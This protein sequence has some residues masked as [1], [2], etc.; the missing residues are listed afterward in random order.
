MCSSDLFIGDS[1]FFGCSGLTS[2]EIPSSVTDIRPNV[3]FKCTGLTSVTIPDGVTT[4]GGSAFFGCSGLT[5]VTIPAS[6]TFIGNLAFSGCSGL[7]SVT[8]PASVTFIGNLAFSGCGGKYQ[9]LGKPPRGISNSSFGWNKKIVY[10]SVYESEWKHALLLSRQYAGIQNGTRSTV[11]IR[12]KDPK[13]MEV[14]YRLQSE[15]PQVKVR[16]VAFKDGIRSFA[17][18]VLMKNG[19]GIPDGTTW[20]ETNKD[21]TFTWN[22]SSDWKTELDKVAVDIL[23]REDALLPMD[24]YTVPANGET[25]AK[26]ISVHRVTQAEAFN[27][28]LWCVVEGDPDLSVR[29]GSVYHNGTLVAQGGSIGYYQTNAALNY[30]YGKMG[31]R[32]LRDAEYDYVK[33]MTRLNL[34]SSGLEQAAV[35]DGA[36]EDKE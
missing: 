12:M 11:A 5:S 36:F 22:V 34:A 10:P 16:A 28:M 26:T 33:G 9:F 2:V 25:G 6:V 15:L 18:V 32:V 20:V 8:I 24:C 30:L 31:Y 29:D 3:F 23:I 17:N 21:Y 14:T 1:A 35:K 13:T 27:A 19:A 7:T 4:I